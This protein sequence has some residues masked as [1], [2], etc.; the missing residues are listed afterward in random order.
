MLLDNN[1][2]ALPEHFFK[3][4]DQLLKERLVVDFNQGLDHRLLTDDVVKRLQKIRHVEYR[5]SFDDV[6]YEK[7]VLSAIKLLKKHGIKASMWF[8]LVGFNSTIEEDL[9]RLN[10]LRDNGQDA[11]VQRYNFVKDVVYIAMAR[12]ANQHRIFRAMTWD[13]FINHPTNKGY[14]LLFKKEKQ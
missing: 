9:Y 14:R 11:F 2:L 5:F 10:L 12:W 6:K 8:V 7:T 4:T 3:I 1:I 13:K